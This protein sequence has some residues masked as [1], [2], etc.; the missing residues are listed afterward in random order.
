MDSQ[1]N[2]D[3]IP[4]APVIQA[5][6]WPVRL[7]WGGLLLILVVHALAIAA[8]FSPAIC[9]PD[10]NGYFAQGTLLAQTG[11]TW[12]SAESDAQYVGMHWLLTPSGQYISRYPPGV[13]ILIA[14]LDAAGGWRAT[15]LVNPILSVLSLVGLFVLVK[16]VV[17][18]WWSLVAVA[19]LA[20]NPTF[21]HHALSGDSHMGVTCV[22]VWGLYLL[23]RWS[24]EGKLWQAFSA[25]M[26]LGCIPTIRYADA[27][28]GAGVIVFLLWHWRRFPGIWWHYFAAAVGAAIPIIPL[29]LRNHRLLGA[30]WRTGY[31][32]TNEATGFSWA[33]LQ[34]HALSY[35]RQINGEAIG[36]FFALGF[37]GMVCMLFGAS[38]RNRRPLA[39]MLLIMGAS[40][41]L[42]YMAYYWGGMNSAMTLRFLLPTYVLYILAG[43]WL[44]RE[45]C[46]RVPVK[47]QVAAGVVLLAFQ[48]IWGSAEASQQASQ[49][50]YQKETLARVTAALEQVARP[51][52][53]VMGT[54]NLLQQ[55]DFVRQWKVADAGLLRGGMG[56]DGPGGAGG[57]GGGPGGPMGMNANAPSPMQAGKTAAQR[58]KYSGTSSEREKKYVADVVAWAGDGHKVYVVGSEQEVKQWNGV[59]GGK[60]TILSRVKMPEAS[61]GPMAMGNRRGQFGQMGRGMMPG[62]PGGMGMPGMGG[63]PGMPP[64]GGMGFGPPGGFGMAGGGGPGGPMGGFEGQSEVVIAAFA[65]Q[66]PASISDVAQ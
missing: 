34:A 22:L 26:I 21:I 13:S 64:D 32:L 12:F 58:A 23:V 20:V 11:K 38:Q 36:L 17:S 30:F 59:A 25:G 7:A 45:A 51:G 62:G 28:M 5:S 44:V 37:I 40:M 3:T 29:L 56:P 43:T 18:P 15:T 63:M 53:V 2:T 4:L 9:E 49:L 61:A 50:H 19:A 24:D 55:I 10:D 57:P 54:G 1:A 41:L 27:I 66:T 47:A 14:I 35:I 52:D 33:Y 60:V 6:G 16:R 8:W 46:G 48:F 65:A 42:V 31:S 39:A